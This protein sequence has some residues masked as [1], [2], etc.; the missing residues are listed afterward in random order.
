MMHDTMG[1][2]GGM[3]RIMG[4]VWLLFVLVFILARRWTFC[5]SLSL[6][7]ALWL[8]LMGPA[9]AETLRRVSRGSD[10]VD[11]QFSP[12]V[13]EVDGLFPMSPDASLPAI[14]WGFHIVSRMVARQEHAASS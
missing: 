11:H 5:V 4:L 6:V 8:A 10:L 3:G 14:I 13:G 2:M 12:S 9:S 1:M 7:V